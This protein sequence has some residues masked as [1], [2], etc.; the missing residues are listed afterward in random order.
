[1]GES[2]PDGYSGGST[3]PQPTNPVEM[4]KFHGGGPPAAAP[5]AAPIDIKT[6]A[7]ER[8]EGVARVKALRAADDAARAPAASPAPAAAAAAASPA[9]AAAVATAAV[10]AAP[11]VTT[12]I[13]APGETTLASTSKVL[14]A[15]EKLGKSIMPEEAKKTDEAKKPEET[16]KPEEAKKPEETKKPEEETKKPEEETKTAEDQPEETKKPE[17]QIK[18]LKEKVKQLEEEAKKPRIP[19]TKIIKEFREAQKAKGLGVNS[20]TVK[21]SAGYRVRRIP[22]DVDQEAELME[23]IKNLRFTADEQIFF[24]NYLKFKHPFIRR[25][26]SGTKEAQERFYSF[27]RT[28]VIYDGTDSFNLLTYKEGQEVQRFMK[29]VLVAYR[30]YLMSNVLQFLLSSESPGDLQNELNPPPPETLE[31]LT[32]EVAPPNDDELFAKIEEMT[33]EKRMAKVKELA[34]IKHDN[35]EKIESVFSKII[36]SILNEYTNVL[37]KHPKVEQWLNSFIEHLISKGETGE[38]TINLKRESIIM[39]KKL[40]MEYNISQVVSEFAPRTDVMISEKIAVESFIETNPPLKEIQDFVLKFLEIYKNAMSN[41]LFIP[42]AQDVINQLKG[43]GTLPDDID[44]YNKEAVELLEQKIRDE[45]NQTPEKF[46][47]LL[48][49]RKYLDEDGIIPE[50]EVIKEE[51]QPDRYSLKDSDSVVSEPEEPEKKAERQKLIRTKLSELLA[52][53]H[54]SPKF[55]I[56]SIINF[57]KTELEDKKSYT[58]TIKNDKKAILIDINNR[59]SEPYEKVLKYTF[60]TDDKNITNFLRVLIQIDL[61][62]F[63][64]DERVKFKDLFIKVV[65]A[66]TLRNINDYLHQLEL[67]DLK[68]V[69]GGSRVLRG[70]PPLR[71]SKSQKPKAKRTTKKRT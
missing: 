9:P 27:W 36:L 8:A 21:L 25:Y 51:D 24:D 26:I 47:N 30:E 37:D 35:Q 59:I 69:K 56:M 63:T 65:G 6:F 58:S 1:M 43:L 34:K 64:K 16:K 40:L 23:D 39:L 17:N 55:K 52:K 41:P 11:A 68:K 53:K 20:P 61:S 44:I 66:T 33:E 46:I 12:A 62:K 50:I 29:E 48:R 15:V 42:E 19:E 31:L 70:T 13:A 7:A 10:A 4:T 28:F 49:F 18:N 14:G 54:V 3:L 38:R 67:E 32:I 45:N 5:A 57:L 71:K 22:E 2:P 60:N